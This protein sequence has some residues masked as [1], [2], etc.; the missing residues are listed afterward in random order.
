MIVIIA[1][2][3]GAVIGSVTAK[4]RGGAAADM[5]QYGAGYAIAFGLVG[6]IITVILHR[7]LA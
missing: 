5:A 4:K 2:F 1:A 3:L 7:S 6:L